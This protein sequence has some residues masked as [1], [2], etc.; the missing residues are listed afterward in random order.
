MIFHKSHIYG[1]SYFHEQFSHELLIASDIL[2]NVTWQFLHK[3]MS[4]FE[5]IL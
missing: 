5:M 2:A 1:T 4:I 3:I